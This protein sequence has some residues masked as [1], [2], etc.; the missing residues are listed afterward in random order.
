MQEVDR[1]RIAGNI[2]DGISQRLVSAWYHLRA[3][4]AL[5]SEP[6]VLVEI[7]ATGALLTD[8]L[9]EARRAIVGLR[10]AVLDDLGLTA[11]I[12]SLATS[13][14]TD[15]E[16]DVDLEGTALPAHVETALYRIAQEALQNV[17][18]H[19]QAQHVRIGLREAADGASSSPSATTASGST[20]PKRWELD[21]LRR[22]RH[23]GAGGPD[24][25]P[26]GHSV[27]A[28]RRLG[29]HCDG[30]RP[31]GRR[32]HIGQLWWTARPSAVRSR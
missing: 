5:G 14:G 23:A 1:R 15:A 12:T 19:A 4:R 2:H 3:A 11:G 25:R 30:S 17:V 6:A 22:A 29:D 24:R 13:L 9:D 8:A 16:I 27:P 18:K 10:P 28:G 21:G 31:H 7:D 20:R 32:E 26:T